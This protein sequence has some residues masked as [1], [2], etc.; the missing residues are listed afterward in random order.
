MTMV[1][2]MAR[3]AELLGK[4]EHVPLSEAEKDELNFLTATLSLT[5]R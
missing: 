2:M 3:R 5:E 4:G 1:A